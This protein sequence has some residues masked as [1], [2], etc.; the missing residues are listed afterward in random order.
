MSDMRRGNGNEDQERYRKKRRKGKRRKPK[1]SIGSILFAS[2]QALIVVVFVV[3]LIVFYRKFGVRIIEL[4]KEAKEKVEASD[5]SVFW[6]SQTTLVYDD[7]EEIIHTLKGDKDVYYLKYEQIPEYAKQAFVSVEDKRFYKHRGFDLKAIFRAVTALVQKQA[8]TQGGS[9][10][11][12]QLSR[13]IFLSHTVRWE[14][15]VEE[16]FIAIHLEKKYTKQQILEYYI[17]NIYYANGYYGIEAASRG[18][19]G[20]GVSELSLSQTAFLCAI[21]NSPGRFDPR[22]HMD[23]TLTRRNKILDEMLEDGVIDAALY[24][25]AKEEKIT[26]EEPE[27]IEASN[28]MQSFA[29]NCAVKELMEK[30]GFE[31]QYQFANDADR[32][33]YDE[34]YGQVYEECRSLLVTGG[35]RV[36]TSLNAEKQTVLQQAV[37][38]TL[39]AFMNRSVDGVYAMQGAAACIDNETG[40][41][42]AI[43]GG[44]SQEDVSSSL[45]RAYQSSRQPG[46]TI[47]PLVVYAPA[48]EGKYTA[49]TII[50]DHKFA[51]G[52]EN[53]GGSYYG[54]VSLRRAV[55]KSLNTVAW[56][57][58]ED[59]GVEAGLQKL[60][61]MEFAKILD[62]DRQLSTSLGGLTRGATAVEMASGY[63]ALANEGVFRAPTCIVKITD[64][65]GEVVVDNSE[66][67]TKQVYTGD[68]ARKMTNILK[69]VMKS[70]TGRKLELSNMPCAGKTGT[71][72]DNKDGWF[73]GYTPYYTTVVWV[74][75]DQVRGLQGLS[76][77]S[78]PGTIWH[79]YMETIHQGL[80]KKEL[81]E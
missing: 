70:G 25:A 33:T 66:P 3:F 45:N 63:A 31:F 40:K 67:E 57:V 15:K 38:E 59:I 6:S 62:E 34:E 37:D 21:P 64:A 47:K 78:Y 14:R 42:V 39:E 8:I 17:N 73:A 54:N 81:K 69:G 29:M 10:I 43:V 61:D 56:Q 32:E 2:F 28:Y 77:A 65:F 1:P 46:S 50:N 71:T 68:A 11:T 52:P 60:Y 55:E 4:Y 26:L 24:D 76:G 22:I 19:F 48:L 51:D 16:I 13:N 20:K 36:Y 27:T 30:Q 79:Q 9:T 53:S 58:F 75:C 74:G 49:N 5:E 23:N 44:R 12:Q 41:V 35:Y 18:Y 7:A 72:N 80:E